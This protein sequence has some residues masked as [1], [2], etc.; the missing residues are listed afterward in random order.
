MTP[1]ILNARH[2]RGSVLLGIVKVNDVM[3]AEKQHSG[4]RRADKAVADSF[5]VLS[6]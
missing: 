3:T 6:I 5:T 1:A 2:P 4:I